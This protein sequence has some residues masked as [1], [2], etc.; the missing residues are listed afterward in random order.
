MSII[1]SSVILTY[2]SW[3]CFYLSLISPYRFI[4]IS[5][6]S[7][8]VYTGQ[9][10]HIPLTTKLE[11]AMKSLVAKGKIAWTLIISDD[12]LIHAIQVHPL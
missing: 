2:A 8:M 5:T 4:S 6:K 1:L 9:C 7:K 11:Y 12:S 3:L 10:M